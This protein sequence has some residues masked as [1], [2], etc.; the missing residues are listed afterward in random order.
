VARH[1][2]AVHVRRV[3]E[4]PACFAIGIEH[5]EAR[6]LVGR[7]AEHVATEVEGVNGETGASQVSAR[8]RGHL[9]VLSIRLIG[10]AAIERHT[11][12][13]PETAPCA[14]PSSMMLLQQQLTG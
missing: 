13:C 11:R 6:L 4:V 1:P 12:A 8:E 9:G 3:D 10:Q 5:R 14:R 2:L 7:P